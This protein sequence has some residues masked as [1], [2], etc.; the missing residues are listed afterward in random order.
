LLEKGA[1]FDRPMGKI[2]E[3]FYAGNVAYLEQIR[4]VKN[5]MDP[6]RI[7]NPDQLVKGV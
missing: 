2:A 5:M 4:R 3:R 7:F 1:Y 6:K